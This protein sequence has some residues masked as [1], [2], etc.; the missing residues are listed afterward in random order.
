MALPAAP[1]MSLSGLCSVDVV[2]MTIL[3]RAGWHGGWSALKSSLEVLVLYQRRQPLT[4]SAQSRVAMEVMRP[5]SAA[6]LFEASQQAS[7]MSS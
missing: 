7:T 6:S 2:G 4:C 5:G 3:D 1:F